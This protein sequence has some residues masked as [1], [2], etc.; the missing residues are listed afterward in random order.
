LPRAA[1]P[2]QH[3]QLK[4]HFGNKGTR[5]KNPIFF[6]PVPLFVSYCG[7]R[8]RLRS[9]S[10][11]NPSPHSFFRRALKKSAKRIQGKPFPV[12]LFE[13]T[14]EAANKVNMGQKVSLS[15][16]PPVWLRGKT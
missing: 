4:K 7:Y 3:K 13:K 15:E 11:A 6:I 10:R 9:D 14:P 16:N 8:I 5:T 2:A 12:H 1:V